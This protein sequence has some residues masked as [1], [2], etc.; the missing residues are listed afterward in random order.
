MFVLTCFNVNVRA[1]LQ[2][3]TVEQTL[4]YIKQVVF[5]VCLFVHDTPSKLTAEFFFFIK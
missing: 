3:K 1:V 5:F 2:I 4:S